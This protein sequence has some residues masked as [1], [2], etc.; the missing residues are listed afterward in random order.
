MGDMADYATEQGELMLRL[1]EN[2]ECGSCGPCP[3]CEGDDDPCEC[4]EQNE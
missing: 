4:I 3:Y 2:G 1:H